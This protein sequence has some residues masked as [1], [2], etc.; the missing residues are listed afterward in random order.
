M[1]F[2]FVTCVQ[3][4]LS[5]M[6]AIY[7]CGGK[8]DLIV[9]LEDDMARAKSGRIYVDPFAAEHEIPVAKIRNINKPDAIA[10][11]SAAGLDWLFVIGWSQ[12]VREEVLAIPA[13][14]V[15]GIHPTLLPVGRGRAAIPWAILKGLE[16]TGV[17]MF[18]LDSGVDTGP[19]LGQLEIPID[20]TT[21][22]TELYR[23]VD[24]AHIQ[25]MRA[26]YPRL[27]QGTVE[28][29]VQDDSKATEWP[30]RKPEDGEINLSGSVQD[31]ERMVRAVTRPYPGAFVELDEGRLTVWKAEIVAPDYAGPDHILQF[32]DGRLRV[33]EGEMSPGAAAF[34]N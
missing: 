9:T 30:G 10:A 28:A 1:R 24:A 31:A 18:K 7:D 12:I 6:K 13:K 25:L 4:G 17:T 3:L 23:M 27:A 15:I 34:T 14:G 21:D 11:I 16:K 5:C 22:A 19:I 29:V 8:L 26:T 32:P 2:G 33:V 20:A